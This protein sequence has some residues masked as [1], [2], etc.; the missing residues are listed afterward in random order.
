MLPDPDQL[1]QQLAELLDELTLRVQRGEAVDLDSVAAEHP[2]LAAELR[3]VWGA[4]MLADAVALN[5]SATRPSGS[6]EELPEKLSQLTLPL[7]F[8]D[9]ELLEELGR[10][11][12]GVVY[13]ARQISLN[14][15]VAV[16]MILKAQLASEDELSRFL[17]EAESA[18]RLSH[19]GIVPVY[20]VGHRDG[21]YYFSMKYIEGETLAERLAR[22]PMAAREVALLMRTVSSAV[23]EAH[24]HGILHRDL[25]PS[26]ILIDKTG[27]PVVTDFGLA[28]QVTGD[29]ESITRSGAILGTPAFMAPEQASGDRGAVGPASDVYALGTILFAMLTGQPPFYGK[30]PVDVLLKVLEQDPPFPHQVNPRV[31][32]DLEM[33]ALR[34]MQKPIDLR[35]RDAQSL[36]NDF[37]A[38]LNDEAISARSGQF[39][40]VISRLFRET[41][42]AQ[43]LENWGVLWMWHSLVLLICCLVTQYLEWNNDGVRWHY[44]L[45]WTVISGIWAA[46]FWYMRR[47][48]G[49]V[50][51][52]ERQIAHVWGA[53][54][55]GVACLFPI[56]WLMGLQPLELSPLLAIISGMI[57]LVK[58]GILTG[59]FY[60]QALALFLCSIPMA[61]WPGAAHLIFGVV[62]AGSFF[63][64]GLQYYRQR[65][66]TRG[67][68]AK[69]V[70][71]STFAE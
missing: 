44:I 26:N 21:R 24:Q 12:M 40:Q 60:F 1:D 34:C 66:R 20:E 42:N 62:A 11:G 48:M 23:H 71:P 19:P 58:G 4:V 51:F 65:L 47:R 54:L 31:D 37:D 55:V 35:Y 43:V 14:R 36:C 28:K 25:K 70:A 7:K 3:E 39:L 64:P 59:W 5:L 49:P 68:L 8:G 38:Y 17:A 9:Y 45:I 63:I 10:G 33:I 57:F 27:S 52:V 22:G 67:E 13:K 16:K 2:H 56:E 61:L 69:I 46:F 29:V 6:S 18:A 30:N 41:H 32:R 15:T 50:T 53:G